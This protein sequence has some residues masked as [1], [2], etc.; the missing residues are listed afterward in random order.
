MGGCGIAFLL[1]PCLL[2]LV[3]NGVAGFSFDYNHKIKITNLI[4]DQVVSDSIVWNQLIK[5]I[6]YLFGLDEVLKAYAT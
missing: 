1:S 2:L 4:S 3:L 5:V 6:K